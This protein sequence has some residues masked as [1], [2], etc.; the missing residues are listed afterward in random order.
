MYRSTDDVDQT[1]QKNRKQYLSQTRVQRN[2]SKTLIV[3]QCAP[4][5][6]DRPAITCVTRSVAGRIKTEH[7]F[8]FQF[9]MQGFLIKLYLNFGATGNKLKKSI[10]KRIINF[11]RMTLFP[12][13]YIQFHTIL[14]AFRST[15]IPLRLIMT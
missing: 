14:S 9:H 8:Y 3:I 4:V 13:P 10:Q 7:V 11:F 15:R 1:K 12:Q 6:A 2:T 5:L